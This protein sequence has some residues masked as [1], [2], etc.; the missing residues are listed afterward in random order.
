MRQGD[1][2]M[3][4]KI[5]YKVKDNTFRVQDFTKKDN[6]DES[7]F[8]ES[9]NQR[10]EKR[11]ETLVYVMFKNEYFN[12]NQILNSH[13]SEVQHLKA[14][15]EERESQIMK[16]KKEN[17]EKTQVNN[18]EVM[19]LRETI[20][21]MKDDREKEVSHLHQEITKLEKSRLEELEDLKETHAN[22]LSAIDETHQKE[23]EKLNEQYQSKLDKANDKLL[24]QV[25]ANEQSNIKLKDEMLTM[26]KAHS[27]EI[28]KLHHDLSN[29]ENTHANETLE[30]TKAHHVEVS[31][32]KEEQS[33]MKESHLKEINKL[34][35]THSDE[36]EQIRTKFLN[37]ITNVNAQDITEI[38]EIQESAPTLLKPF[39]RKHLK[40]LEDLKERKQANT[41]EKIVK[42]YELSGKKEKE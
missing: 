18:D 33:Q 37:L 39:M 23:I 12:L 9:V 19:Q 41:P 34:E 42:T 25:Q 26:T 29:L 16:L 30:L 35:Q 24:S 6:V 10:G 7:K 15:I 32:L 2:T 36:R 27:S 1:E 17:K 11:L 40:K 3:F 28:E 4:K 38:K 8:V 22:Q 31:Q 21:S 5:M 14:M 13:E 20:S